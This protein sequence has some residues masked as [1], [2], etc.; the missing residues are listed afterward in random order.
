VSLLDYV[1][2]LA[3]LI[4]YLLASYCS[5]RT[6]KEAL[7]DAKRNAR[8]PPPDFPRRVS[9]RQNYLKQ[10]RIIPGSAGSKKKEK[11]KERER[12]REIKKRD[13][14]IVPQGT[15]HQ[16]DPFSIAL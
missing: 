9:K 1:A 13:E 4:N 7:E 2:L 10:R 14:R 3:D 5:G 8:T 16:N 6:Q 12:E 11:K 15:Q